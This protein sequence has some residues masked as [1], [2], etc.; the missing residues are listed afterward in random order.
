M[1]QGLA[2]KSTKKSNSRMMHQAQRLLPAPEL[3]NK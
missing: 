2:E 1:E 3:V